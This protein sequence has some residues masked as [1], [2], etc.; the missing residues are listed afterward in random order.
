M[1]SLQIA[2][3]SLPSFFTGLSHS[4]P[5]A[6]LFPRY[7]TRS[8]MM[9][10]FLSTRRNTRSP[11]FKSPS[12]LEETGSQPTGCFL[13]FLMGFMCPADSDRTNQASPTSLS[14]KP[15]RP[16]STDAACI[17]RAAAFGGEVQYPA[18]IPF[19]DRARDGTDRSESCYCFGT[20]PVS[21][22]PFAAS[23][24]KSTPGAWLICRGL[25]TEPFDSVQAP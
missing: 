17:P 9:A 14:R 21:F 7:A 3:R 1:P 6:P 4:S 8:N 20:S 23:R 10:R 15:R 24:P 19:R 11:A 12:C 18:R 25:V 13:I 2:I 16:H 5:A 22:R